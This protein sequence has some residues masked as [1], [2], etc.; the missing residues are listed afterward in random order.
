[1]SMTVNAPAPAKA[2]VHR[3]P[4][5]RV[6]SVSTAVALL[7]CAGA[8]TSCSPQNLLGDQQLPPD[9]PDP[10]Q[11][12]TP[13]GAVASY[14]G[15]LLQLRTAFG[16]DLGFDAV[17]GLFT[18][19]LEYGELGEVGGSNDPLLIDSRFL[20][21]DAGIGNDITTTAPVT[22]LYGSLQRVRG[23]SRQARGA[24]AAY[25][26]DSSHALGGHLYAVEGYADVMLADLYCSGVPLSTLDFGGDFTYQPGSTTEEVYKH[27]A[28]LFDSALAASTDSE[29]VMNLARVG[30]GRALLAIG[31]YAE[32]ADAV[33]SVPSNFQ[34]AL[35][36][37]MSTSPGPS[38]TT[39]PNQNF[40]FHDFTD[41]AEAVLSLSMVNLEGGNGLPYM[42]SGDPRSAFVDNGANQF[43]VPLASP[44]KYS[45]DGT[46]PI[47]LAD[48]IEARLI[49]AEA[50]LQTTNASWLVTLNTLRTDG[51]FDT[52]PDPSDPSKTD[53]L[54][55]AG[56][57]GMPGLAPLQDP[58][59]SDA[60]VNL[61]FSERAYW[62]FLTGHRQGDLRRLVRQYGR[63]ESTVYPVGAY[64]GAH[65]AYGAD[66]NAPIPGDERVSNPR[67]TGCFGRGA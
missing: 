40:I 67:F 61:L 38:G 34:Y 35:P 53:T 27:A 3:A 43:G 21:E 41:H 32:A 29:R 57:G 11:T 60:R 16:G 30:K 37:D 50:A 55:H 15:A 63:S 10:A 19:E 12:R 6:C 5:F 42:S 24:L 28:A 9:V 59:S 49:E 58:G 33:A 7:L 48:G 66:V 54:W 14:R 56:T 64:R 2:N 18:D 65:D 31:L 13:S 52:Q 26:P 4:G 62:L 46:T 36:F 23:Q 22:A 39:I 51:T 20:V 47:V 25:A 1:M 17:T 8:M 45:P 44:A